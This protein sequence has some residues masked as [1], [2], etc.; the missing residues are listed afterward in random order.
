MEN[1]LV[2]P[3]WTQLKLNEGVIKNNLGLSFKRVGNRAARIVI[4]TT[5]LC[6]PPHPG[7]LWFLSMNPTVMKVN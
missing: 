3:P 1:Q 2:V 7:A 4:V 6:H 5:S